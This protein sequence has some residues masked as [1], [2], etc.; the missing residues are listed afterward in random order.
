MRMFTWDRCDL[1]YKAVSKQVSTIS[2]QGEGNE[3]SRRNQSLHVGR[4]VVK[5]TKGGLMGR[6]QGNNY[7]KHQTLT[8]I[9]RHPLNIIRGPESVVV[10]RP[11]NSQEWT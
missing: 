2:C 6:K 7:S 1:D 3:P 8:P 11:C 4:G 5:V 10:I 9:L